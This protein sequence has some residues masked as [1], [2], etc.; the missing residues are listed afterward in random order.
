MMGTSMNSIIYGPVP[1]WRLGSSLGIDLISTKGKTCSF[2]CIYCQ[3]G[4]TIHRLAERKEFVTISA[5][6]EELERIKGITAD[7]IT[8]SGVGEPTLA[9]NLSEAITLARSVLR[10]P[11]AVLTNSSLMTRE[12]VRNDLS[13]ANVVVA[14]LDAPDEKMFCEINRPITKCRLKEIIQGMKHFREQYQ[15]RLSLQVMFVN[16]NKH[17]AREIAA[18]AK[19]ISPDEVQLNTPLRPCAVQPLVPRDIDSIRGEFHGLKN[20][21]TVYEATRPEVNPL[22]LKETLKRRPRINT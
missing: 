10:L 5:L 22:D 16:A 8:F 6:A 7:Y 12:D 20:V 3:L 13:M 9:A 17:H 14:K 2:D 19:E 4:K 11:V 18:I 21:V 1:S 15:G